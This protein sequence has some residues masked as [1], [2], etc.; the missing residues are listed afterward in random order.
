MTPAARIAAA[1]EAL[2]RH[3][4]GDPVEVAL[5]SWARGNRFA[6][7]GDRA[8]IRDLVFEALR[9]RR[10]LAHR[11]GVL[12]GRGLMLGLC[13]AQGIDPEQIFSGARF[14]PAAL[15]E[16]ER[17]A[18]AAAAA[19]EGLVA[20][21]CPDW[22]APALQ[23][24]L[25][26]EFAAVMA[27]Q[28][29]R[30]PVFLRA[31]LA[32]GP[33]A[34]AQAALAAEGVVSQPH[35]L[36]D[37]ALEVIEGARK[38]QSSRAYAEGL[39]ELQDAASQAM[40]AALP[41]RAGQS[42]LDYCAGGGGKVL[43]LAARAPGLYLAHDIDAGRMRDLPARAERAGVRVGLVAP[44]QAPGAQDLVLVDAPCSGS[45]TWRRTPEAKWRLTPERLVA[46]VAIQRD[47]LGRAAELVRPGGQLAYM[48][49][50][51]LAAENGAQIAA[52]L[53][54]DPRFRLEE[55]RRLTPLSGG[56]GF[57]LARMRRV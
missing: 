54:R 43:A 33:R 55:E 50:S 8:A 24:S 22:I 36:A 35:P 1:I 51:L 25:G 17:A 29:A 26:A 46:L 41:V 47:I 52:F 21:D 15:T 23:A 34:A 4:A 38:I 56:D 57:Y 37:T 11:G 6:G 14:A 44:G 39:V 48:T 16:A 5:I 10:S 40:V 13:R 27:A 2:D 45:G 42:V 12:S 28:Q 20:L 31:N 53:A 9:R 30:A 18:M 3:L 19:P 32:R 49:C 7:S